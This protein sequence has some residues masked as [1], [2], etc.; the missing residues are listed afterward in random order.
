MQ[1]GKRCH[2]GPNVYLKSVSIADDV[3]IKANSVIEGATIASH[4]Q[5]GPFARV[6]PGSVIQHA[7]RVGN[8]VEMKQSTLGEASKVSHLSYLGNAEVGRE[9]NIGAGTITCNYDGANKHKTVIAD[10]VFVGS[11]TSL[12]APVKLNQDQRLRQ[13][14]D[15]AR[16]KAQSLAI[17]RS[18]QKSIDGWNRPVK[19]T[20]SVKKRRYRTAYKGF[21]MRKNRVYTPLPL[22]VH[23]EIELPLSAAHYL[24]S[25]L[26]QEKSTCFLFNGDGHEYTATLIQS[27]KKCVVCHITSCEDS[28]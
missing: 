20:E 10:G 16:V 1:I 5:V 4:A 22:K 17:T 21:F 27:S 11:N 19:K 15:Y 24:A 26:P 7:A 28:E 2:I 13:I 8:F 9:V 14:D 12:V 3:V 23:E 25:V 6:R 18:D